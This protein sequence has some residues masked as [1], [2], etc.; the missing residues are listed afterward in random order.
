MHSRITLIAVLVLSVSSFCQ[1]QGTATCDHW[2]FFKSFSASGISRWNTIVGSARESGGTPQFPP[3]SG[4]IRWANGGV[5][6]Y[7]F[8]GAT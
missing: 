4:Y 5:V 3:V 8:P 6:K 2:T 7:K 1:A